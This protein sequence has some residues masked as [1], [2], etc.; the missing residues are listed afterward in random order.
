[1][2]GPI[3]REM[4]GGRNYSTPFP[5]R[6]EATVG[7]AGVGRKERGGGWGPTPDFIRGY[8]RDALT[9]LIAESLRDGKSYSQA[10]GLCYIED[11]T[12]EAPMNRDE[13]HASPLQEAGS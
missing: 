12:G 10:R 8:P 13:T 9:G 4:T 1:M 7:Q 2:V 11:K 5:L 3:V 6:Q